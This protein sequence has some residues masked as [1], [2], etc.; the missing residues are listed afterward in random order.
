[1]KRYLLYSS[2]AL[3]LL[4]GCGGGGGGGTATTAAT[5]TTNAGIL[6]DA[7]V[8]GAEYIGDQ[9]S[10]G[11]TD[12]IGRFYYK[13]GEKITFK[14]GN[15]VIG[16]TIVQDG[17][18]TPLSL[19][20]SSDINDPKVIQIAKILLAI[21]SDQDP[22]NGIQIPSDIRQTL[23]NKPPLKLDDE[24]ID[25]DLLAAYLEIDPTQLPDD[26]YVKQHIQDTLQY[27]SEHKDDIDESLKEHED[28]Y[29]ENDDDDYDVEPI[30]SNGDYQLLAW[31]DLGM[32]CMDSNYTVFSILPPYNTLVAQ[33]IKK[34]YGDAQLVTSG[35]T[36][37]Y[38]AYPSLDG[39]LNTT[40]ATKTNFWDYVEKLFGIQLSP[41]EGLKG[42]W[43][44]STT[45]QEMEY[46]ATFKWFI[47]EGIP[48]VPYNDDFTTNHYPLVKVKAFDTAG[49]LLAE[50]VT[51]LPVSDEMDCKKCHASTSGYQD[52]M[53]KG[54]WVNMSDPEL[55]FRYNILKLHD[56]KHPD[57][58]TNNLTAL[59][60]KG[61]N[62]DTNLTTTAQNGTPILCVA[63]HMSNAIPGSG[64]N[65]IK[66]LTQAMHTLHAQV[67]DPF[68][69][70]LTLND[71][72][73]KSA[74]YACHPGSTTQCLRGA[75]GSSGINCQDCHGLMSAVG[76]ANRDG[77]LDEPN[78]QSCHHDGMREKQAVT[79][80]TTG[81]L[82]Q[83]VDMRFATNP[84]TPLPGKSLYR[85]S[86]G[87]G[88]VSCSS[89]HGSTHAIYPS[90]R[91][92]D[93]IQSINAQG[94]AGTIGEC[95][96]CHKTAPH[97]ADKGPHGLHTI[98]NWWVDEHGDYA[99]K[100]LAQCAS[101]H[102]SDYRGGVLSKT[103]ADRTFYLD[104][105]QMKTFT[106]GH[107]V[108]CYD[109]HN[110]PNGDDD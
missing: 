60:A 81:T 62:Y 48:T 32:H 43:V 24:E 71:S 78:C 104:D 18:I 33:L 39:K 12:P 41:D 94:H 45:P 34:E 84:D 66:P 55:D 51:V 3:A 72:T 19:A 74:C 61:Y 26:D 64:I 56:E 42:Y 63:C 68:D 6:L 57:A 97:T 58:V 105:N 7:N 107:Q 5:T 17:I 100:N 101:C 102:G 87:H 15:L 53:P 77:W 27:I 75:M 92:E 10:S 37:T 20:E 21:D 4:S 9:G 40:S 14:I 99:E 85:F 16:E 54:G 96:A 76:S 106:K 65:G 46:N 91:P 80:M 25:P 8:S 35:V 36:V 110:G 109:C 50:T 86:K 44:Q 89:C 49:N 93:N 108:S 70:N 83:V 73:N 88:G 13:N 23:A 67:K 79:D 82:R 95:T 22:T 28:E 69:Q 90:S 52:A 98:G 30:V 103:M 29:D 1:M 38:E 11:L 31:N 47:A 2:V 59:Q